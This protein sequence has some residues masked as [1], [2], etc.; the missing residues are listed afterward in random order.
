MP[1]HHPK[2][3]QAWDVF[4]NGKK[5]DTVFV[6]PS[7][8]RDSVTRSL[9][10]HDGYDPGIVVR[11]N[12]KMASYTTKGAASL[13]RYEEAGRPEEPWVA[14]SRTA[15]R[16]QYKTGDGKR[17]PSLERAVEH[18]SDVH[19]RTG[20]II[21]VEKM[22]KR[23][24]STA[25]AAEKLGL[26]M[27]DLDLS[28]ISDAKLQALINDTAPG[29]MKNSY[30]HEAG[31][32]VAAQVESENRDAAAGR[33]KRNR[34]DRL[35]AANQQ[36]TVPH[37]VRAVRA[38]NRSTKDRSNRSKE[39]VAAVG[40]V[41]PYRVDLWQERDRTSVVLYDANDVAVAEW[42]DEDAQQMFEDGFFVGNKGA[43]RFEQSVIDYAREMGMIT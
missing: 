19:R 4:L 38:V 33:T 7:E 37:P 41:P 13:R 12:N 28:D 43:R 1:R 6:H 42:W 36:A 15:G 17:W 8:D 26:Q 3:H 9:V 22:R 21:S 31:K 32:R 16:N 30:L 5:I 40:F 11:K 39:L 18:A 27:Q 2:A 25:V 23:R 10:N 20:N 34:E 14:S 24:S 35:I 29:A